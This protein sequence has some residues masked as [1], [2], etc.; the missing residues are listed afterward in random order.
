MTKLVEREGEVLSVYTSALDVASGAQ[1][2]APVGSLIHALGAE[3][4]AAYTAL[5]TSSDA[6]P[7]TAIAPDY[8]GWEG[9]NMRANWPFF[10]ALRIHYRP[11]ARGDQQVVWMPSEGPTPAFETP[12]RIETLSQNALTVT[13]TGEQ[14][15]IASVRIERTGIFAQG[16]SALLTVSEDSPFTRTDLGEPWGGFPRYGVA[17]TALVQIPAP[18]ETGQVTRLTLEVM[19]GSAIGEAVCSARL[20]PPLDL[21]QI[22][23]LEQGIARVLEG[24]AS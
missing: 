19:D 1:S 18:I 16:R 7:V 21:T 10:E 11:V 20:L 5:L 4:R 6:P 12:C 9:W 13:V 17:N 3:N 22:P 14:A 15:G 23:K 8:S 2:P 24:G